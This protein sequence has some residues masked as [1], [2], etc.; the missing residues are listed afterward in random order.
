MAAGLAL[1]FLADWAATL[2]ESHPLYAYR[3]HFE[4][5]LKGLTVSVFAALFV[6]ITLQRG[7]TESI[8]RALRDPG[9]VLRRLSKSDFGEYATAYI[10]SNY[11]LPP[12]GCI[13]MWDLFQKQAL[14]ESGYLQKFERKIELLRDED[15]DYIRMKVTTEYRLFGD[16]PQNL[17]FSCQLDTAAGAPRYNDSNQESWRF[18]A[19]SRKKERL[20]SDDFRLKKVV[21]GSEILVDGKNAESKKRINASEIKYSIPLSKNLRDDHLDIEY[22]FEV[23]QALKFGFVSGVLRRITDNATII[24]DYSQIE[25]IDEVLPFINF[26]TSKP[27]RED[28]CGEKCI[29]VRVPG[30][31]MVRGA[32]VFSWQMGVDG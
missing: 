32:V 6:H 16:P 18:V 12:A 13:A 26:V 21:V 25:E 22:T 8:K 5:L 30:W 2:P 23:R 28:D 27:V 1:F 29:K 10:A 3:I 9:S 15:P 24:L 20:E 11:R 4:W 31:T 19:A 7:A 14:A 17:V